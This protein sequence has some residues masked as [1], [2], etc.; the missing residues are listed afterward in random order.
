M[1]KNYN[2]NIFFIGIAENLSI[3]NV[4]SLNAVDGAMLWEDYE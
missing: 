2:G 4:H 1:K 3:L